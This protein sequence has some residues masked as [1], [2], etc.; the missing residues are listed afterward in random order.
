MTSM[1][2]KV[3]AFVTR[4][5]NGVKELLLFRHPRAGVQ[6][7]AGT[8]EDGENPETAVK[9]EVYEE[10]G[11]RNVKIEK[12]LGC[13][14]NELGENERIIAKTTQVYSRP[15]LSSIAYKEELTRGLTVNYNSKHK[16]FT[17]VSYIE[18]DSLSN[19]ACIRCNV[20]GWVPSEHVIA[21]K[22]R[23]FFLLT[24][25]GETA[26]EWEVNGD[27]EHV[28]KLFWAPISATPPIIPPQDKWLDYVYEE[29]R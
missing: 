23:Y 3:A 1:V 27:R 16:E 4:K 29:I 7:P 2:D 15:S 20:A 5:R 6:I 18:Y 8:V 26:Q 9:R 10:T 22:T 12:S 17:L 14:E 28:F 13:V 11:L 25:L 19:A 24:T 21:R